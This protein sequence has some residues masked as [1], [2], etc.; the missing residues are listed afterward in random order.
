MKRYSCVLFIIALLFTLPCCKK[1]NGPDAFTESSYPLALGNWWQY[2]LTSAVFNPDTFILRVDSITTV[3]PYTQYICN[4]V[5]N[6]TLTPAG[7]FLQSDTSMSFVQPY[8]YFTSFPSF[9]LKFPVQTGQ[10]WPGAFPGDSI[11]V[12][13][14]VASEGYYGHT[15]APCYLT[16]ES[17]DLPHNFK[18]ESMT[19]TPKVGLVHQTINFQSDTAGVQIQQSIDLINYHIQ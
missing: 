16:N 6:G 2:Q 10:Y 14:V 7:Y 12:D 4:Y 18:V 11:L 9:H 13:A 15:Y 8:G 5:S 1:D 19:L 3:G 17:Y